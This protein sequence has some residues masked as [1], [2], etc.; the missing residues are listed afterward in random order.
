MLPLSVFASYSLF[1]PCSNCSIFLLY[2]YLQ[3]VLS[4]NLNEKSALAATLQS[5]LGEATKAAATAVGRVAE[6]EVM[7]IIAPCINLTIWKL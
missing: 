1:S 6:L 4:V 7:K 5:S 3:D 2:I